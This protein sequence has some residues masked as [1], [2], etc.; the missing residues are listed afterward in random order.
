M[1]TSRLNAL[2][3]ALTEALAQP[4]DPMA[5]AKQSLQNWI[6]NG[7]ELPWAAK[8]PKPD[9]M[10]QYLL[11]D[12]PGQSFTV[13]S[14]VLWPHYATP[15]HN[16]GTWGLVGVVEGEELEE[17]FT[18]ALEPGTGIASVRQ[19]HE[20]INRASDVTVL[21][22]PHDEIHRITNLTALPS[23]SIHV[24]GGNID[25]M[26]RFAYENGKVPRVFVT[27]LERVQGRP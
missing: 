10:V 23:L 17:R 25:G 27:T 6:R 15:I 5:A 8:Q 2:C 3:E 24:Y 11:A 9:A 19:R 21:T 26:E 4:E 13:V 20:Q 14:M 16:H 7:V 18:V 12:P 1:T 22:S